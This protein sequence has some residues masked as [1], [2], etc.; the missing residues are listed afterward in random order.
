MP[1]LRRDEWWKRAR[2]SNGVWRRKRAAR[3]RPIRAARMVG[4]AGAATALGA[5][6]MYLLDP[7]L[8][9]RR[10]AVLRDRSAAVLRR[11]ARRTERWGRRLQSDAAGWATHLRH[12]RVGDNPAPNDEA[13]ADRVRSQVLRDPAYHGRLNLNAQHGVVVLRGQLDREEQIRALVEATRRVAG[14]RDV[15]SYLHLPDVPPPNKQQALDTERAG[16]VPPPFVEGGGSGADLAQ[17][18]A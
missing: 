10:R 15:R 4:F 8:G 14:V 17:P 9:R 16:A 7:I 13:L 18:S 11:T 5:G 3:D 2:W 6:V 12:L 1:K